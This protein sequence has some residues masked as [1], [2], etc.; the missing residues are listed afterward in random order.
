M[1]APFHLRSLQA[2]EMAVRCGSFVGAANELG[3]T[4]AAV[5]QRVKA[6]EDYLGVDLLVRVRSGIRPT[7]ELRAALPTLTRSF[8]ALEEAMAALEPSAGAISKSPRRQTWW[9]CGW[10]PGWF[11]SAPRTPTSASAST[12]KA[13]RHCGSAGWMSS[14]D[15][16]P[17]KN[18]G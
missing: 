12:A 3:I 6:L 1:P 17:P 8:T 14:S 11:R 2:I 9:T 5:G 10:H 13:T 15:S 4:P 7:Q 16:A 18:P